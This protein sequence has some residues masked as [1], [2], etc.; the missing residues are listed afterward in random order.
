MIRQGM[1]FVRRHKLFILLFLM[2]FPGSHFLAG[3]GEGCEEYDNPSD[4]FI[5][6][7]GNDNVCSSEYSIC[8][9]I[10]EGATES[11]RV[12]LENPIKDRF[13]I[14]SVSWQLKE[15]PDPRI[16]D[17]DGVQLSSATEPVATVTIKAQPRIDESSSKAFSLYLCTFLEIEAQFTGEGIGGVSWP[18]KTYRKTAWIQIFACPPRIIVTSYASDN[19]E[20]SQGWVMQKS[21]PYRFFTIVDDKVNWIM[22]SLT[23]QGGTGILVLEVVGGEASQP[24]SFSF[25][26]PI[27]WRDTLAVSRVEKLDDATARAYLTYTASQKLKN[28]C[29]GVDI[30]LFVTAMG[31]DSRSVLNRIRVTA[32]YEPCLGQ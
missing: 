12:R 28:N 8:V 22:H 21:S 20:V 15:Y 3:C 4:V 26:V 10:A 25:N 32:Q 6:W 5:T 7:D 11:V 9:Q 24:Y 31:K 16:I 19:L 13:K 29:K 18:S 30:P 14:T 1:E 27:P 23:D 17:P 2:A